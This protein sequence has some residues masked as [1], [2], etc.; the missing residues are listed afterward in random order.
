MLTH[1]IGLVLR[2]SRKRSGQYK[3]EGV[4]FIALAVLREAFDQTEAVVLRPPKAG[5]PLEE[6]RIRLRRTDSATLPGRWRSWRSRELR[7]RS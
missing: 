3:A 5:P 7:S 6:R 1:L 2:I 4:S